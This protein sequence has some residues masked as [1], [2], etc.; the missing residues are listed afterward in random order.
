VKRRYEAGLD[1]SI[2]LPASEYVQ[3][4]AY[5]V[6]VGIPGPVTKGRTP[7]VLIK[8]KYYWHS[9]LGKGIISSAGLVLQPNIL[10]R[11]FH[12]AAPYMDSIDPC[13]IH[14]WYVDFIRVC[15]DYGIYVPAYEQFQP[16][17][18]YA[19]LICG[20]V[21]EADVPSFYGSDVRNWATILHNHFKKDKVVPSSHP[22]YEEIRYDTN[23]YKALQIIMGR[24][25]PAYTDNGVLIQGHPQQDRL[26]LEDHFRQAEYHYRIQTAFMNTSHDWTHPVHVIRFLD[27]CKYSAYLRTMY[28][29]E[30][31]VP[32]CAYKF[33][34]ERLV[35]TLKEYL[36]LPAFRLLH[37]RASA[38]STATT[39]HARASTTT[40]T[41]D[42][43]FRSSS[44]N[45]RRSGDSR[46]T[47]R[48]GDRHVRALTEDND[49]DTLSDAGTADS[50]DDV[51]EDLSL[52]ALTSP[53]IVCGTVHE[54]YCCPALNGNAEAQKTVFA[55]L[56]RRNA[57]MREV[58]TTPN[59]DAD[60]LGL[61]QD[62]P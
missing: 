34:R 57:N 48:S 62:F 59:E 20:D 60:L 26:T 38:T 16:E 30:R 18:S 42:G 56:S 54:P 58:T 21:E 10:E 45:T 41:A 5:H 46:R 22:N 44:N 40:R 28:D 9:S 25:H 11:E 2:V 50:Q 3:P 13:G 1:P 43:R 47:P 52:H 31:H 39:S 17:R 61:D 6:Q 19:H 7:V 15:H 49:D 14:R 32:A 4:F 29:Q 35:T 27:S 23:G 12:R 37:G 51:D 8:R 53:C 36:E 33:T 55:K 24:F